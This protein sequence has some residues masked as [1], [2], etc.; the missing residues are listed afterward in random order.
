MRSSRILLVLLLLASWSTSAI[1]L[2]AATA[3]Q[4][5]PYYRKWIE[6]DVPYII[7]QDEKKEF[8]RLQT[9]EERSA[10]IEQFWE[11]R[12]P[13]PHSPINTFKEEHYRRLAYVRAEYGDERYNDGWRTDMGR[14]YITLGPPQ[15]TSK[16]H[17]GM[18][19]RPVEIWFYQSP[20]P[21]LPTYFNLVL[22]KRSEAD[23][24]TLYSPRD[25]GPTRIVT[26]DLHDDAQALHTID[27]SMGPEA[28]HAMVSL[29][30]SEPISIDHPSPTMSSDLLLDAVRNLP[31]QKLEKDRIARQ[32]GISREVVTAKIF[33]GLKASEMETVVLRDSKGLSTLNYIVRNEQPDPALIG[34]LSDKRTGYQMSVTTHVTT[35][36]G[37]AIYERRDQL[38]GVTSAAGARAGREKLFAAEGRLPLVPGTYSVESVL[39]NDLTH[40]STRTSATVS[41]PA[42]QVDATGMSGLMVYRGSPIQVPAGQLPFTIA[43]VRFSPRGEQ[44]VALHAGE[45]LP[46]AFQLWLPKKDLPSSTGTETKPQLVHVHYTLGAVAAPSGDRNRV[47]EDQ[48]V[49]VTDVDPAG[50][51]VTGHTLDTTNLGLGTYRLVV[52]V[53]EPGSSQASSSSMA[54]KIVPSTEPVDLWTAFGDEQQHPLWQDD[55]LR[56]LAAEAQGKA[57]EA[58][59][60]YRRV[61]ALKPDSEDAQKHLDNLTRKVAQRTPGGA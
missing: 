37:R 61:L 10:F 35:Q 47:E 53:T 13:T 5:A 48:D 36:A 42:R 15:Q 40:E 59:D 51:L 28:T 50:N 20:S 44:T 55:F 16:F 26:N 32:R 8:L 33:T 41:V 25:D 4:L 24:Y 43:G 56:G 31:E 49:P 57:G 7:N 17:Q 30:P 39:T 46:L 11:S 58:T 6:E 52:K 18:S 21:A 3:R 9:D 19:T 38:V 12:N 23:P 29:L 60:C 14:V 2:Q 54:V 1:H 22:Y 45:G 27:K 34:V